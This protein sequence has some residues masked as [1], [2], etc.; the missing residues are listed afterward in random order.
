MK[1][2]MGIYTFISLHLVI[3]K[4]YFRAVD[5]PADIKRHLPR[6]SSDP[7]PSTPRPAEQAPLQD[8]KWQHTAHS[9]MPQQ[10]S[11]QRVSDDTN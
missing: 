3:G 11:T 1:V 2:T 8:I 6:P 5:M 9:L 7:P 4:C 10:I